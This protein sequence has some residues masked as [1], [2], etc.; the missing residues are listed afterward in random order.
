[1]PSFI[2]DRA[3]DEAYSEPYEYGGQEQFSREAKKVLQSLKNH[4]AIQNKA[5]S[6]DE[7]SVAKAVWMLQVDGL[8]ALSDALML[9]DEKKH[10][11]AFRV[12]RDAVETLDLSAYFS[13]GGEDAN[14]ALR[15]WYGDNV[16]THSE[17]RK[18]VRKIHGEDQ[19]KKLSSLYKELSGFTHRTHKAIL[20]SYCVVK[21]DMLMYDGFSESRMSVLPHVISYSYALLGGLIKRFIDIAEETGQIDRATIDAIWK[22]CV[23]KESVPRRFGTGP[24]QILRGP[25]MEITLEGD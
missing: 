19:S 18:F 16:V 8:E 12:F 24:G 2:W 3:T 20:L 4:Y 17:Y 9:I 10:R 6:S 21:N 7:K 5:F 25:P 14:S 11:L 13:L 23:E 22:D 1:M 15:K